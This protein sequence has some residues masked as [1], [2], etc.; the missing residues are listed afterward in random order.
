MTDD[1]RRTRR[2]VLAAGAGTLAGLAGC[3]SINLNPRSGSGDTSHHR[4]SSGIAVRVAPTG[5]ALADL[6]SLTVHV[7]QVGIHPRGKSAGKLYADDTVDLLANDGDPTTFFVLD[8][9]PGF[10]VG[11]S[12]YGAAERATTTGGASLDAAFA[13]GADALHYG[14][15]YRIRAQKTAV[16]TAGVAVERTDDG[17]TLAADPNA[18]SVSTRSGRPG[19]TER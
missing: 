19:T 16:F 7:E 14:Q 1:R 17:V 5:D 12:L 4:S 9:T 2:G 11:L 6:D 8:F 18:T 3:S 10:Y 15:Q 13:N